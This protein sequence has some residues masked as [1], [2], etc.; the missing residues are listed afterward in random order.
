MTPYDVAIIGLGPAG[1]TLARL[2]A[3]HMRVFALN[4]Q[5]LQREKPCGGLLA[6]DAQKA[7]AALALTLPKEIL[8]SP[9]IFA[10]KTV[11]VK[12]RLVR[13]YPRAYINLN[14]RA[15]DRWLVSLIPDTAAVVTGVCRAVRRE[16]GLFRVLYTAEG[17]AAG[18]V[19][20]RYLVGADGANSLV[21]K[22][23]FPAKKMQSY[24]AIQQ[25]FRLNGSAPFYSCVFDRDIAGLCAWSIAKDGMFLFGGA[26]EAKGCRRSFEKQKSALAG[27]GFAFGEPLKTEACL[28]LRPR[29]VGGLCL[30]AGN[31]LLL[32][33]AA[34]MI[35][36]SSL[37]G[38]S[39]AIRGAACLS[40]AFLVGGEDVLASYR[41]K[42]RGLRFRL[43]LKAVKCPFLYRPL[44]RTLVMKS[45]LKAMAVNP[46]AWENAARDKK[47]ARYE[48]PFGGA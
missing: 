18:E 17:G 11:D 6:P 25:W 20:A 12:T 46:P 37:E 29:A 30:G 48:Q 24:V 27:H 19:C 36:P 31:A 41:K 5:P 26:Y 13:H 45:G 44:L 47:G 4:G 8:V 9:Q 28:V 2:L 7:L 35:S 23:L 34:G 21:R 39:W 40:N 15:F 10:V 14:R 32:G 43:F 3:P 38:I 16:G 33:E 42:T 1:A 22:T